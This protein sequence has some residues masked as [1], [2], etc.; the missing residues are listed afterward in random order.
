MKDVI[1]KKVARMEA[2][3]ANS[4]EKRVEEFWEI[5]SG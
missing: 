2:A 5:I 3:G 1:N 4:W